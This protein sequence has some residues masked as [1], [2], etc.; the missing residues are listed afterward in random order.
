MG[1]T[2]MNQDN[3]EMIEKLC[4]LTRLDCEVSCGDGWF[5]IVRSC[6]EG[7]EAINRKIAVIEEHVHPVQIKEKF[8]TLR[9]YIGACPTD[10]SDRVYKLIE[11]AEKA[12]AHTCEF[13]G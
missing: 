11:R 13:C 7:I 9:Y 5:E 10:V 4:P 8:G 6:T 1:K 12:S 3:F 2:A